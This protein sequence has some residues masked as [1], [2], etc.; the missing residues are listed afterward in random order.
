MLPFFENKKVSSDSDLV[1]TAFTRE[2]SVWQLGSRGLHHE[3]FA[4]WGKAFA[5]KSHMCDHTCVLERN[6]N[7]LAKRSPGG[8]V[9][10]S[11]RL[12]SDRLP[13]CARAVGGELAAAPTNIAASAG[14]LSPGPGP[15]SVSCLLS[16]SL[17]CEHT[18]L[19]TLVSQRQLGAAGVRTVA[20]VMATE[21]VGSASS[22]AIGTKITG[23]RSSRCRG[24]DGQVVDHFGSCGMLQEV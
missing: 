24:G 7:T 15:L 4:F 13:G 22:M 14:P 2:V 9:V 12:Y 19:W 20:E 5:E 18:G 10:I 11:E 6:K 8:P 16:D 23:F 21:T 1:H 17:C 3:R